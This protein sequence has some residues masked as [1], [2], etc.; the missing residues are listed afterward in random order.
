[1]RWADATNYGKR[2]S[3]RSYQH[4]HVKELLFEGFSC[5]ESL[6]HTFLSNATPLGVLTLV[7]IPESALGKRGT[8][9]KYIGLR[10]VV[11]AYCDG[12]VRL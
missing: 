6:G 10:G 2:V 5:L 1:M 7:H 9:Y 4:L 12:I 11:S 3:T 8:I